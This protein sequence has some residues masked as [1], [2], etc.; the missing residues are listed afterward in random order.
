MDTGKRDTEREADRGLRYE[1][2]I[3]DSAE[4]GKRDRYREA[5]RGLQ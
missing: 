2:V 5:D 3:A 1:P 4:T